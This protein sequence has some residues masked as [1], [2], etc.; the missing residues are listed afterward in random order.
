MANEVQAHRCPLCGPSVYNVPTVNNVLHFLITVLSCGLWVFV[1]LWLSATLGTPRCGS[2]GFT[3]RQAYRR[4][5]KE[6]KAEQREEKR[7]AIAER[8]LYGPEIGSRAKVT[9]GEHKGKFG[10]V[11][12][13]DGRFV[14]ITDKRG[15]GLQV[16]VADF[17]V[18]RI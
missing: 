5:K 4:A 16:P 14:V 2:C 12:A 10:T 17:K 7:L 13:N 9:S 8:N 11:T 18:T 3:S 6:W 15:K 1:W